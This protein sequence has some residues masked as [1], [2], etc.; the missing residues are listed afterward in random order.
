MT[1]RRGATVRV[2]TARRRKSGSTRWLARHLNDPYVQS[3]RKDGYRSRAAYKLVGLDERF[4]LLKPGRH[5]LDL[6]CAPGGWTQVAAA[7]GC[8]VVGLDLEPVE[9]IDGAEL[10]STLR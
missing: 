4:E 3:A 5:V 8:R 1:V 6:G 10:V 2:R 9:P 7:A